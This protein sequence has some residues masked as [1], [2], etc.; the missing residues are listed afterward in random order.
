MRRQHESLLDGWR[1]ARSDGLG[2]CGSQEV[3]IEASESSSSQQ[4][5]GGVGLAAR[6]LAHGTVASSPQSDLIP[7][8]EGHKRIGRA[9]PYSIQHWPGRSTSRRLVAAFIPPSTP[10]NQSKIPART[11]RTWSQRQRKGLER[12]IMPAMYSIPRRLAGRLTGLVGGEC[13]WE[14][15][16]VDRLRPRV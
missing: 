7:D 8:M 14:T 3:P 2:P 4:H 9:G 11:W 6:P 13:L 10:E 5:L 1:S 12:T 15:T 16:P